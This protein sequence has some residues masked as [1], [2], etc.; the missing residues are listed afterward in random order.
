VR[1]VGEVLDW[2]GHSPEKLKA[3]REHLDELKRTG[4]VEIDD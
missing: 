3:M 2:V 1:I 4:A